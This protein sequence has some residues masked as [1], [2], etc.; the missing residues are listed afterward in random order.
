MPG[1]TQSK[2]LQVIDRF[3]AVLSAIVAGDNYF[4][5]PYEVVKGPMDESKIKGYPTY[6]VAVVPGGEIVEYLDSQ[7]AEAFVIAVWGMVRDMDDITTPL[8]NAVRDVRKAITDDFKPSAGAGSLGTLATDVR[9]E[10]PPDMAYK[11]GDPGFFGLF[12]QPIR[13]QLFGEFGEI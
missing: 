12:E 10:M 13:V 5:T 8:E 6:G 1:P 9:I 11:Y 7:N 3:K 4:Y 2:R